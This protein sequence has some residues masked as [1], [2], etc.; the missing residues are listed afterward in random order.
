MES[1]SIILYNSETTKKIY[2]PNYFQRDTASSYQ[3]ATFFIQ[4]TWWKEKVIYCENLILNL[5]CI[6]KTLA[7]EC[8][9]EILKCFLVIKNQF[10]QKTHK[11]HHNKAQKIFNKI[12]NVGTS[13]WMTRMQ[14]ITN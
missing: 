1:R 7:K 9:R 6:L 11:I 4:F 8:Q 14:G 12:N 3:F 5:R 10:F 13:A 2:I